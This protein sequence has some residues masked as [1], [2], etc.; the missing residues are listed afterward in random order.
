M[1]VLL[2]IGNSN[3]QIG[4]WDGGAIGAIR[5]VPTASFSAAMLPAG[6]AVAAATVVPAVKAGLR[7]REVFFLDA[8]SAAAAGLDLGRVDASTPGADR[9][10][11]ALEAIRRGALPAAVF[12]FGTA[13]T[14]EAVDRGGVFAG[15]A[16]APGRKLMRRALAA[17]TAQLPEVGWSDAAPAALGRNTID[18]IRL[19]VDRGAIGLTR[20]LIR[21]VRDE[22]VCRKLWAVGG[23][24]GFFCR[25]IP[26]LEYGGE[27]F[28]LRGVLTAYLAVR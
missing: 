21:T 11:N 2:N 28:T 8:G 19:G 14:C 17:D 10:A 12:D 3:T 16:I 15:G 24:A 22:L 23:D 20:E 5:Y 26:D 25:E 4:E 18:A 9:L 27:D 7:A 1:I 13:I 6:A